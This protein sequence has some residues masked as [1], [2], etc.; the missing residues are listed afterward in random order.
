[1]ENLKKIWTIVSTHPTF[2]VGWLRKLELLNFSENEL[3][4][5]ENLDIEAMG[6]IKETQ[7]KYYNEKLD[8]NKELAKF[9]EEVKEE[10]GEEWIKER[11]LDYLEPRLEELNKR[12]KSIHEYYT[13]AI[14]RDV[15]YWLR[16][17]IVDTEGLKGLEH[18]RKRTSIQIY[19]IKHKNKI[20][21]GWVTQEQI[22]L[23]E[24]Y[25]FEE[26]V[27]TKK[28]KIPCPFHSET[29]PSFYIKN[30][31]GYCFGCNWSGNTI[32]F[33]MKREGIGF[34]EAVKRLQL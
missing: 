20:K 26:L 7:S 17:S 34:V 16:S 2:S 23:A 5:M 19:F 13:N 31:W 22:A 29:F 28:P 25:P 10:Q 3:R 21:K 1:M 4:F 15:P 9:E 27:G 18:E 30:N 33:I 24:N 14:E 11:K 12:I 6:V 8:R 32:K